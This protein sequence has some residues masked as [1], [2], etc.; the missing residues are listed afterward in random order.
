MARKLQSG[1]LM[2]IA[3]YMLMSIMGLNFL[4]LMVV[5]AFQYG[6]GKIDKKDLVDMAMVLRG[7]HKFVMESDE[8]ER[9]R[10]YR[11]RE[12]ELRDLLEKR[13]GTPYTQETEAMAK[14]EAVKSLKSNLDAAMILIKKEQQRVAET[15]QQVELLKTALSAERKKLTD[16]ETRVLTA[17]QSDSMKKLVKTL[18]NMDAADIAEHLSAIVN[19]PE[20]GKG[21]GEAAR[22]LRMHISPDQSAEILGE[23]KNPL[24]RQKILPLLENKYAGMKPASIIQS[25]EANKISI[26]ERRQYLMQMNSGQ[27][28]STY[29]QMP[30][31]IQEQLVPSLLNWK[32]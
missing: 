22:I 21:P 16:E 17:A 9:Y 15:R 24:D 1:G 14:D 10:D 32:P 23:M 11:E 26:P 4:V 3:F 19:S 5:I 2:A 27:A 8:L 30:R 13:I 29:L 31:R 20:Q 18:A 12:S 6:M 7:S 28:L 25:F